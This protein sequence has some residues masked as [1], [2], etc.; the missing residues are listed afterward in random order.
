[1]IRRAKLSI[2]T[3]KY[4]WRVGLLWLLC[5]LQLDCLWPSDGAT[6]SPWAADRGALSDLHVRSSTVEVPAD[7]TQEYT[8]QSQGGRG[9]GEFRALQMAPSVRPC[10]WDTIKTHPENRKVGFFS[11]LNFLWIYMYI[12]LNVMAVRMKTLL[13]PTLWEKKENQIQVG[14]WIRASPSNSKTSVCRRWKE[15]EALLA[16]ISYS[17]PTCKRVQTW[18]ERS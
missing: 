6:R 13:Q 1:M 17:N 2:V 3:F 5:A 12:Y 4:L 10:L 15:M 9:W 14:R 7:G 8:E 18:L 11:H 16:H